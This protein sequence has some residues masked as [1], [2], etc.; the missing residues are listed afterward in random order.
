MR[1]LSTFLLM[2]ALLAA[3]AVPVMAQTPTTTEEL[4]S[5][6]VTEEVEPGVLRV[7][8]HGVPDLAAFDPDLAEDRWG[9]TIAAGADGSVW[10]FGPSRFLRLGDEQAYSWPFGSMS[11]LDITPDGRLWVSSSALGDDEGRY[12]GVHVFDGDAPEGQR[13][14]L[15][16]SPDGHDIFNVEVAPD[17]TIWAAWLDADGE[18][19]IG[20]LDDDRWH[21]L[22]GDAPDRVD[23]TLADRDGGY[24]G[25]LLI[26]DDGVIRANVMGLPGWGLGDP[27]GPDP[28]YRYDTGEWREEEPPGEGRIAVGP[29]GILWLWYE[30][31]Y[32]SQ[33]ARFDGTDWQTWGPRDGTPRELVPGAYPTGAVAPDGSLWS[34]SDSGLYSFDGVAWKRYMPGLVASAIEFTPDGSVWVQGRGRHAGLNTYVITPEAVG[35]TE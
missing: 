32:G 26:G 30:A 35:A 6:M 8:N 14:S 21:V 22:D 33:V 34:A 3:L 9:P 2:I 25:Q 31:W 19:S 10:L 24:Y 12:E 23:D 20:Q 11:D 15:Q 18:I 1:R 17:G 29:D 7:L 4:L 27:D 28:L 5:G 13:W 16:R